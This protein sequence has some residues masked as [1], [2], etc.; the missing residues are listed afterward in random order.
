MTRDSYGSLKAYVGDIH[1]HCG[2]SY[3]H[4]T[5]EE[6]FGN[7]RSQLDFASVTGHG[8]WHDIPAD[9]P[10]DD[11]HRLGFERLRKM[12]PHVQDVTE[13]FHDPGRFVT[14]L[15]F[16]WH[17]M[18]HGDYCIY[19][20][21]SRGEIIRADG[22][23]ALRQELRR[24]SSDGQQV[25]AIPHHI[26]YPKGRRGL[27]WDDFTSEFSPV[28]E[29]V[30]MHGCGENDE[31]PLP[32]LHVM[33]PRDAGSMLIEGYRRGALFGVIGSSDH[34]SAHP[35]SH[36][37]GRAVVWANELS[38]QG[39]WDAIQA[40][41]AYAI[42]GDRI[43]LRFSVDGSPMGSVLPS[44]T[45]RVLD[46]DVRGGGALDFVDIV[47]D[48]ERVHRW[49]PATLRHGSEF[50]GIVPISVGWGHRN[51]PVDW[52]VELAVVGGHLVEVEPRFRGD[53]VL[54]P[55]RSESE[56]HLVSS[57][58]RSGDN[59]VR[60]RTTTNGNPTTTTDGTQGLALRLKG[61]DRTRIVG[62][63]NDN[64]VDVA[65]GDLRRGGRARHLAGVLRGSY[66]IG[67]AV[68]RS[69]TDTE[70]SWEDL[71]ADPAETNAYYVRV[72]QANDQWA[73]S[74][75]IWVGDRFAESI[76]SA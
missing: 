46:V 8:Y 62:T 41:R 3:G 57:W 42:T 58:V 59:G 38:R 54:D 27:N 36:G 44:T 76:H 60:F 29:M 50:Q 14:F 34:H 24:L 28:V 37:H 25:M 22:L 63:V 48:G 51:V 30:S 7:A 5:I 31:A 21:A 19:F 13:S 68:D 16:E 47:K 40:R 69:E 10:P 2:I 75:P 9:F 73:W 64:R 23:D 53:E 32:Y 67:R 15:S 26:G 56:T 65:V 72:R 52:S 11:Y 55:L 4:G 18:T 70:F 33:G 39:I 12:W 35:G 20:N 71:D 17:S 61:D 45:K 43:E 74:S 49:V 66:R 6:A 1:N